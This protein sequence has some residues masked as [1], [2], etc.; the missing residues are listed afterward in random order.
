MEKHFI[1]IIFYGNQ[2]PCILTYE[3]F[4]DVVDIFFKLII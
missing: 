4:A 3:G 2:M 1:S